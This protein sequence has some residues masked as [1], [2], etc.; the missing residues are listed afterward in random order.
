MVVGS[1]LMIPAFVILGLTDLQPAGAMMLLGA[2]FVL[3]PAALWPAVPLIVARNRT[4]T[5][6]ALMTLIQN[7]GLMAFPYLNGRLREATGEYVQ[8]MV[9]FAGLGATALVF[10]LLLRFATIQGRSTLEAP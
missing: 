10:A 5:A 9:M 3:V 1:A 6:F 8:S 7:V 2:A 4:G